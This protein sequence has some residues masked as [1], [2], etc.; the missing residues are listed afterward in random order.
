MTNLRVLPGGPDGLD[1]DFLDS[2]PLAVCLDGADSIR[3]VVDALALWP[4]AS[5]RQPCARSVRLDRVRP[6]APLRPPGARLV[7]VA[8]NDGLA[9]HLAVGDGW[10]LRAV[11]WRDRSADVTVTAVQADLARIVLQQATRDA[12]EPPPPED[13]AVEIGFWYLRGSGQRRARSIAIE[14]WPSIRRNYSAR[15][16]AALDGL[17]VITPADIAGRL[18]LA[19]GPPGTGKTTALRA[20]AHAWRS[21][22]AV[23]C[24]LDPERLFHEPA[25]LMD[26]VLGEEDDNEDDGEGDAAGRWRLLILEDCDELIRSEAKQTAGQSLSRLLNLTDGLLGQGRNVLVAITANEDLAKLHPAITRPGRCLAQL[27]IGRLPRDEAAA[28][29]GTSEGIGDDGATLA[30]LLQLQGRLDKIEQRHE[31]PLI[32][33]FQPRRRD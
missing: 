32:V 16:A 30:E 22:C 14:P 27:E 15:A 5:G 10:T 28:W 17:M 21:W 11:R 13:A 26:V 19:H 25:Y 9:S 33:G 29:L 18:L 1:G 31:P 4:F 20:V 12:T 3:D 7:R 8:Y 23:D 24:V 6:D 2:T